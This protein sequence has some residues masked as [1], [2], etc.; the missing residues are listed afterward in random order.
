MKCCRLAKICC[1]GLFSL[2]AITG[3]SISHLAPSSSMNSMDMGHIKNAVQCQ[4]V[5]MSA[6]SGSKQ[7]A[8]S[9]LDENDK[10]PVITPSF[11]IAPLLSLIT[12]TFVVKVVQMLGSWRP[13]DMLVLQGAYGAGL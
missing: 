7:K 2:V 5:C 8:P 4:S 9:D 13:P 1:A 3:A 6:V 10:Q 11:I 12:L